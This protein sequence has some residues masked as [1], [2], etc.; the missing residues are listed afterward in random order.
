MLH[1][2]PLIFLPRIITTLEVTHVYFLVD[3]LTRLLSV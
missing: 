1:S 3:V 2:S